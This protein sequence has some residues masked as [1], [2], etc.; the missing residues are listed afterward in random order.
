MVSPSMNRPP[1]E[2]RDTLQ[3]NVRNETSGALS[4][5]T[6]MKTVVIVDDHADNRAMLAATLAHRDYR[7]VEASSGEEALATISQE[8]PDLVIADV[9]MPK[10]DGYEFVQQ[11]RQDPKIAQTKVVFCTASYIEDESRRLAKACGVDHIIVK[12]AEPE[13]VLEIVDDA[14]GERS[15]PVARV[16]TKEFEREHL[17]LVTHKLSQKVEELETLT[18]QLEQEIVERKRAED[19]LRASEAHLQT[20]VENLDEGVIVSDLKGGLLRWSRAALK[21]HGYTNLEEGLRSLSDFVDTFELSTLDGTRVPVEDWPLARILSGE[22]L[23]DLELRVRNIRADWERIFNYGGT[24]VHDANN[25]PLMAIVTVSDITQRK[26]AEERLLEQADIINHARD[27]IIIRNCED[28]HITFWNKGAEHLYGWSANEALRKPI[29]ELLYAD[30][31]ERE[32]LLKVLLSAGEFHGELKQ[33]AKDGRDF[34]VDC[35]AT[36]IRGP[37]GEPGSVLLINTDITEQK[38]LGTRLL[39]AQRLES[40]GTLAGGVAHELNNVLGPILMGAETLRSNPDPEDA[41]AMISLIEENARRGCSIVKQVLTFARGIEGEHVTINPRH[42]ID[43]MADIARKTFPKSIDVR[44][45]YPERPWPIN[46]DPTQLHQVLLNLCVNAR[47]AMANGGSLVLDL[48]NF[49]V[50]ENYA[51][52]TPGAKPGPHV[53]LRVSDTGAGMPRAMIDKIFDPFFTTKEVGKG[54]GL[55]LSTVSG[56]VKSH[57]GFIFVSSDQGRGT[58]FNLFLPAVE[59]DIALSEKESPPIINGNGELVLLVDDEINVRR[60]TKMTL[61]KYNYRVLEASDPP[62]AL[63]IFAQ[64]MNSVDFVLTA[65]VMPYMDGIALI[66]VLKKMQ[67][68]MI[69]IVSTEQE[70]EP[71]LAEL[72]ELGVRNFLIKP[73]DTRQLLT[74]LGRAVLENKA[75]IPGTPGRPTDILPAGVGK[76]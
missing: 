41:A 14:L 69:F 8:H 29:G 67:P 28:D 50:D 45:H 62:E 2:D 7:L 52:M 15:K 63:A 74:T 56:I 36:L 51:A 6:R 64:Q 68:N 33:V 46:G 20:V 55:G 32:A 24:L 5:A 58:T 61:E 18:H 17:H 40:I 31:K 39:R 76:D 48:E 9:L 60:V 19:A 47:D 10:M 13:R 38:K 75:L 72:K 11:L 66:R 54:T 16:P 34:I 44:Q 12:P 65:I 49:N 22:N 25:K 37:A 35:R 73:F 43:E 23:R 42:L 57:G 59:T 53:I 1:R 71:R 30:A 27:A 3:T 26:R 21:I 4:I 70:N